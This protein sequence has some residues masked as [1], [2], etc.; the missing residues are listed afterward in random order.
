MKFI[1][2][3]LLNILKLNLILKNII[4]RSNV[5]DFYI[6]NSSFHTNRD[7]I[8]NNLKS[9]WINS[10]KNWKFIFDKKEKNFNTIHNISYNYWIRGYAATQLYFR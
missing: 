9:I 2:K 4:A 5:N 8:K 3:F 1:Y 10:F 7:V 6:I